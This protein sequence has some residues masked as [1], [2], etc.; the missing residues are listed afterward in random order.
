MLWPFGVLSVFVCKLLIHQRGDAG[1]K[2]S[3]QVEAQARTMH[4]V[5]CDI[6]V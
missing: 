3:E 5:T 4:T 6:S 2:G 1:V